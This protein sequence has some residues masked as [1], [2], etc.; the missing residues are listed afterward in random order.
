MTNKASLF[1]EMDQ[2]AENILVLATFVD[3]LRLEF[4]QLQKVYFPGLS[5]K[6]WH[7]LFGRWLD[8]FRAK[9][10]AGQRARDALLIKFW[11]RRS[12]LLARRGTHPDQRDAIDRQIWEVAQ[13]IA[14]LVPRQPPKPMGTWVHD[15]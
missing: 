3:D 9:L 1:A 4:R 13:A 11:E 6:D 15:G 7:E 10:E 2:A 5:E 12:F 14:D 8:R